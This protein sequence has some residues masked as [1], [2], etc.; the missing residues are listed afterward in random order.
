MTQN[1]IGHI[2]HRKIYFPFFLFVATK[3]YLVY[4]IWVY[5][6]CEFLRY[7][8]KCLEIKGC[9]LSACGICHRNM[10]KLLRLELQE[11]ICWLCCV[12]CIPFFFFFLST[13]TNF[14]YSTV[15]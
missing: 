4:Y 10:K 7:I 13:R 3:F 8:L 5:I 14:S 11:I 1:T 15:A 12:Q 9:S 2:V 6:I